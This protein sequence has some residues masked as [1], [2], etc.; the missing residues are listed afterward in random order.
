MYSFRRFILWFLFIQYLVRPVSHV[1]L[2]KEEWNSKTCT[3]HTI[4]LGMTFGVQN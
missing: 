2:S 1:A 4:A 3:I